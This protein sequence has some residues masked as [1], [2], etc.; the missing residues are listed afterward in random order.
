MENVGAADV[1]P[2]AGRNA[3]I[4]GTDGFLR[5]F[6][7]KFG[8]DFVVFENVRFDHRDRRGKATW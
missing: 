2:S 7:A 8:D 6:G 5:Y 4:A 1:F 3:Y